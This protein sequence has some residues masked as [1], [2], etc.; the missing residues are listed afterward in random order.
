MAPQLLSLWGGGCSPGGLLG[1]LPHNVS[2]SAS[3]CTSAFSFAGRPLPSMHGNSS[4]ELGLT[5]GDFSSS[6]AS[7]SWFISRAPDDHCPFPLVSLL[8][9]RLD[10]LGQPGG[11]WPR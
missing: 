11:L 4:Q 7:G 2:V 3:P 5:V 8:R 10:S 1:S 9:E 6:L